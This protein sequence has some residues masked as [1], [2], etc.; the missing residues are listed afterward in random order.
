MATPA[1]YDTGLAGWSKNGF[2][3]LSFTTS[4]LSTRWALLAMMPP[5]TVALPP[6]MVR[7]RISTTPGVLIQN[8][9]LWNPASTLKDDGPGPMMVSGLVTFNDPVVREILLPLPRSRLN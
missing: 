6:V 2:A 1:P 4:D 9:R 5:P 8:T 3:Q 7:L